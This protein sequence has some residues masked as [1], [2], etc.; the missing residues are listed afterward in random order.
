M[1][2]DTDVAVPSSS[3]KHSDPVSVVIFNRKGTVVFSG[4][5][6]KIYV[7]T[8]DQYSLTCEKKAELSMPS[9][10][11]RSIALSHDEKYLIVSGEIR[12][13]FIWDVEDVSY[14]YVTVFLFVS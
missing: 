6:G 1:E 9:F 2:G 5:K 4:C 8:I 14:C 13:V 7:W 3:L 11:C 12:D 10:H